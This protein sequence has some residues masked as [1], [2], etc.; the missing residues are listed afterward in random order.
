M[1]FPIIELKF[2][3]IFCSFRAKNKTCATFKVGLTRMDK[4]KWTSLQDVQG[5]LNG[6][7]KLL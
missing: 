4:P 7:V 1:L 3:G 6:F 2:Q 5:A